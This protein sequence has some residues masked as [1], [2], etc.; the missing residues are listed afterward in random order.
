MTYST[1]DLPHAWTVTAATGMTVAAVRGG[2][3][4]GAEVACVKR[5]HPIRNSGPI[6][7]PARQQGRPESGLKPMARI[8][9]A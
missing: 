3:R 2:Q 6:A 7:Q 1:T 9:S 8:S 5:V 4:E